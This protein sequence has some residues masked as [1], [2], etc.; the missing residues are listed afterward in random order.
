MSGT[1]IEMASADVNALAAACLVRVRQK[2]IDLRN[3]FIARERAAYEKSWW[4]RLLGLKVPSDEAIWAELEQGT[5]GERIECSQI[6]LTGIF[7]EE[8]ASQLVE[9][10]ERAPSVRISSAD[11]W[12]MKGKS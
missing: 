8:I 6:E 11:L 4:R 12:L 9:A 5:I 7:E 2:R 3:A 10:S 1:T